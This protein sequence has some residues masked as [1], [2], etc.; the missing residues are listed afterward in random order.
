MGEGE[1]YRI[2]DIED[3]PTAT[4]MRVA[5]SEGDQ[6]ELKF[7]LRGGGTGGVCVA[8]VWGGL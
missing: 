1:E 5:R 6:R 4:E 7:Q 2:V 3:I 8:V